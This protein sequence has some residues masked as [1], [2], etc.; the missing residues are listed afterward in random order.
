MWEQNSAWPTCHW[1]EVSGCVA[2]TPGLLRLLGLADTGELLT[3]DSA[4]RRA[5]L[6]GKLLPFVFYDK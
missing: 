5:S 1:V 6:A 3:G 4:R 2:G